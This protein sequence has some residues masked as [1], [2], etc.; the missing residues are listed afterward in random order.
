VTPKHALTLLPIRRLGAWLEL[1]IE[2]RTKPKKNEN[3]DS[4]IFKNG[5]IQQ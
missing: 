4:K 5:C 1:S 3:I 2:H